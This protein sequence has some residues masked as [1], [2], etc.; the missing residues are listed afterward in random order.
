MHALVWVTQ[1]RLLKFMHLLTLTRFLEMM[2]EMAANEL[3]VADEIPTV[4]VFRRRSSWHILIPSL[5]FYL[6]MFL[7]TVSVYICMYACR[8]LLFLSIYLSV[9]LY[10]YIFTYMH[11]C[12]HARMNMP[13]LHQINLRRMKGNI[14]GSKSLRTS[15]DDSLFSLPYPFSLTSWKAYSGYL[16][17]SLPLRIF[18]F[19]NLLGSMEGNGSSSPGTAGYSEEWG[20]GSCPRASP[21]KGNFRFVISL[22]LIRNNLLPFFFYAMI[23][24][25][26]CIWRVMSKKGNSNFAPV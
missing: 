19:F 25:G 2:G 23:P 9:C 21:G 26:P 15:N 10:I 11:I 16:T 22:Q 18:F 1:V 17:P 3:H 12:M 8:S 4:L 5:F 7:V 14:W 6:F 13:L 24:S 20:G